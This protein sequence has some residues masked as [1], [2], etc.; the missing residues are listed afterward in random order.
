MSGKQGPGEIPLTSLEYRNTMGLFATGVTVIVLGQGEDVRGMTANAVASL[1]LDPLLLICC[2]GKEANCA[3]Y[4][5][6]GERFSLNILRREQQ[7]YSNYFAG[8]WR[9]DAPPPD[10]EFIPWQGCTRLAGVMAVLGC[11]LQEQLEGGDHWIMVARVVALWRNEALG[12]PLIFYRGR[13]RE[14]ADQKEIEDKEIQ[15]SALWVFP[16]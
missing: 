5:R 16:W 1:S 13:Y 9:D 7:V 6:L 14:L 2:I 8:L 4:F 11:E 10:F 3:D 12:T 15:D